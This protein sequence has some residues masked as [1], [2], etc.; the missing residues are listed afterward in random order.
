MPGSIEVFSTGGLRRA[1][2]FRRGA[3]QGVR[4]ALWLSLAPGL[5]V[6]HPF[7]GRAGLW[8]SQPVSGTV[9]C[10][11]SDRAPTGRSVG[12]SVLHG[13]PILDPDHEWIRALA[14]ALGRASGKTGTAV[15]EHATLKRAL[16]AF[17]AE[18][19]PEVL[20]C[21]RE[22]G[23][24]NWAVYNHYVADQ[25][26]KSRNRI[27]AALSHP[28]F[29]ALLRE[30]W[31]LRRAV[32]AAAPLIPHLVER[33]QVS[34]AT[35]RRA[36][37]LPQD[38]VPQQEL[39]ALLRH[40]DLLPPEAMPKTADDWVVFRRLAYGLET[41]VQRAGIARSAAL[42][43]FRGG[44]AIGLAELERRLDTPFDADAILE[45]MHCAYHYG[46]R[47]AVERA[48]AERGR[49]AKLSPTPPAAFFPLWFSRY[50]LLRLAQMA[51]H[52][53]EA[54]S[55]FSL[56][57]LGAKQGDET[58]ANLRW[59]PFLDAGAS[60]AGMR[61]VE[62]TSY[63]ALD[64]EGRRLEHCVASY[65]GKCLTADSAIF[66][67]RDETGAPLSTFEVQVPDSAPPALLQH[68]GRANRPPEAAQQALARRFVV[69]VLGRVPPERISA[70]RRERR[71]LG[72]HVRGLLGKPNTLQ[73]PLTENE[74][75]LL[76]EATAPLHPAEARRAGLV[77][78]LAEHGDE[79]LA[80]VGAA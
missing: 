77:T 22:E 63:A 42:A 46:V 64:L 24:A 29:A 67:I 53:G 3:Q 21:V 2:L 41:L 56:Q 49:A 5:G 6:G 7:H 36:R 33:F 40:A 44:W 66:S 25:G 30:D 71:A 31:R 14:N 57:R 20:A 72:R 55:Q 45:M 58:D 9:G 76:G 38:S 4:T 69:Q 52:W 28:R 68:H 1:V 26:T 43:P 32:D 47:P 11:V 78:Y 62:L 27:Q 39:P 15:L 35:I 51:R 59:P 16:G 61:V 48:L 13:V 19:D 50:G 73:R 17:R 37:N 54:H 74:M 75:Q 10:Y 34:A 18:L 12:G 60:H 70:V 65:A 23:E 80:A 8:L 79:V